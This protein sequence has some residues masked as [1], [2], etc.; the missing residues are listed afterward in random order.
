MLEDLYQ[1]EI[2]EKTKEK[3]NTRVQVAQILEQM[4]QEQKFKNGDRTQR[5]K[6]ESKKLNSKIGGGPDYCEESTVFIYRSSIIGKIY[7]IYCT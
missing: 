6:R 5:F 3:E 2:V 4:Y 7:I 1:E